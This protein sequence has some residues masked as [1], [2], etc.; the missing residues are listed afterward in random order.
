MKISSRVVF[1]TAIHTGIFFVILFII[2]AL[3]KNIPVLFDSAVIHY[4][5]LCGFSLALEWL[6]ALLLSGIL[7]GFSWAFSSFNTKNILRFSP[8]LMQNFK[9]VI[10][11]SLFGAVLC[12]CSAEVF[13]PL[14][15]SSKKRM[16]NTAKDFSWYQGMAENSL[17]REFFSDAYFYNSTAI[18]LAGKDKEHRQL[19]IEFGNKLEMSDIK[20][21]TMIRKETDDNSSLFDKPNSFIT[22]G[23]TATEL[24]NLARTAFESGSYFDAHYNA[25][26][27]ASI[28]GDDNPNR[29]E[30]MHIA[31]EAWN[32]LEDWRDVGNT[33]SELFFSKKREAYT[34]LLN[35]EVL[36]AYYSFLTLSN[37]YSSDPDVKKYLVIAK[38]ALTKQYFFIE[39]T[40]FVK[41]FEIARDVYFTISREDGGFI[42]M[43]IRGI[44]IAKGSGTLVEYLRGFNYISF[45]K[46]NHMEMSCRVPFAKLKG[47]SLNSFAG[48]VTFEGID[49][50]S[51]VPVILLNS[52]SE[53]NSE[54]KST[55]VYEYGVDIPEIDYRHLVL[56]ITVDEFN[57]ACQASNGVKNMPLFDLFSFANK[58]S[59]FGFSNAVFGTEL[60]ARISYPFVLLL[61]FII[62]A[63]FGWNYRLGFEKMFK[64]VWIFIFPLA[65]I[66]VKLVIEIITYGLSMIYFILFGNLG[67]FSLIFTLILFISALF[68]AGVRFLGLH[69]ENFYEDNKESEEA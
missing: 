25:E 14:I 60:L 15:E 55:P 48:N 41:H 47:E 52:V 3:R 44:S 64:F 53:W 12:F 65:A 8:V 67:S 5:I 54:I 13:I 68:L 21:K 10:R 28:C 59:R 49:N 18:S 42:L 36:K 38:D 19:A 46:D 17:D 30:M 31:S 62:A 37:K 6:P 35:G 43:Y 56:P 9:T 26:M 20:F 11:I 69:G 51:L 1:V 66:I 39:E 24:L 61:L 32:K 40:S 27:A 57:E 4:R 58:A 34:A 2:G 29:A 16:S 22:E 45:S 63:I 33:E 7:L 23:K 50:A